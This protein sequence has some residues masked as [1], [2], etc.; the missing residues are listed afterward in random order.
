MHQ[1]LHE[2]H[3]QYQTL[4]SQLLEMTVR[5][6]IST[7]QST[8]QLDALSLMQRMAEQ[9]EKASSHWSLTLPLAE[10]QPVIAETAVS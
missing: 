6:E 2:A 3:Q 9:A 5:G 10:R 7:E 4:K 8:A 1:L